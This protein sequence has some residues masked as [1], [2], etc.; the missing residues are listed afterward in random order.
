M[1]AVHLKAFENEI[2]T[3]ACVFVPAPECVLVVDV[4][5]G[6]VGGT[7]LTT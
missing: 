6:G 7:D 5:E 3:S 2:T 4:F 1:I